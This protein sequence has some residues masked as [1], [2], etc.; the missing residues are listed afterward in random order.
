MKQQLAQILTDVVQQLKDQGVIP[1]M[2]RASML[3]T[4]AIKR[5]VISRLTWR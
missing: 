1:K 5:T 4:L 3:K 2:P